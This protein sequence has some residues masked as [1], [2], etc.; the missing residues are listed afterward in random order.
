LI[1]GAARQ[2]VSR[3]TGVKRVLIVILLLPCCAGTGRS[4]ANFARRIY[5]DFDFVK[6]ATKVS[7]DP[8]NSFNHIY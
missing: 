4:A 7:A 6:I 3:K 8:I 2:A 5:Y 1:D